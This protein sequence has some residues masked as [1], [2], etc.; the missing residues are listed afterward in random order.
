[1]VMHFL[2]FILAETLNIIPFLPISIGLG[3]GFRYLQAL[4]LE[5]VFAGE[6]FRLGAD[7][8]RYLAALTTISEVWMVMGLLAL[9][10]RFKA[11]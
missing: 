5:C 7:G 3:T 11:I 1:M 6:C 10:N 4:P 9:F 2:H 8:V